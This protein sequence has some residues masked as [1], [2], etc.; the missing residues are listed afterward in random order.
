MKETGYKASREGGDELSLI[1]Y[2]L[3]VREAG[4]GAARH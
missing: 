4:Q 3:F 1:V 2:N